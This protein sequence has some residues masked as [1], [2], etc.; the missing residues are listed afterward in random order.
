M[1]HRYLNNTFYSLIF[2]VLQ[3]LVSLW[4]SPF[5]I[6]TLG[7]E[8]YG[9]IVVVNTLSAFGWLSFVDLGL[10]GSLTKHLAETFREGFEGREKAVLLFQ[11]ALTI[12]L[13]C[14]LLAGLLVASLS[15][16]PTLFSQEPSLYPLI[17]Q[18]LV[19]VAG[20]NLIIFP[21]LSIVAVVEGLQEYRTMKMLSV[22]VLLA[23]AVAVYFLV[24]SR[25]GLLSFLFADYLKL[26]FQYL[27]LIFLVKKKLP[28]LS[29]RV[30]I[31]RLCDLRSM[32]GLSLDLLVSRITGLV[33]NQT[34]VLIITLVLGQMALVSDYY[35]ANALFM[36]ILS[37]TSVFNS[38]VVSEVA[39]VNKDGSIDGL[40]GLAVVGTRSTVAYVL[41]FAVAVF[42]WAPEI[43][44]L[45][46]GSQFIKN[47]TLLRIMILAII[48]IATSGIMST[49]LVGINRL[50][51][52]L[53]ISLLS[54]A[55]NLLIS[56]SLV[57]SLNILALGL[58]TT[59]AY[60]LSSA[61]Y[62]RYCLNI[63]QA[64]A[65]KFYKDTLVIP[66]SLS[67]LCGGIGFSLKSSLQLENIAQ[68][69]CMLIIF[70]V[71]CYG[72]IFVL[73]SKEVRC[74]LLAVVGL[75]KILLKGS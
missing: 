50:R 15:R 26:M 61:L 34:D 62:N 64:K 66:L 47:A 17:T 65:G 12:Y 53:W 72:S 55:T 23:W 6:A 2:F 38:V 25:A 41:P 21:L 37:I 20:F 54:V 56:I 46:L 43:L 5:I 29:L 39:W 10:Q 13:F 52:A 35:S 68:L 57:G 9:I 4:A 28:W 44:N 49:L 63:L 59:V 16:F 60:G 31:P 32:A 14:G 3:S 75:K 36:A 30:R 33:F 7:K 51:G 11:S 42:V 69:L 74:E 70:L 22:A 67:L 58:G 24:K 27:V 8:S 1:T 45:W 73:C 71:V 48:P 19:V 40:L 18:A